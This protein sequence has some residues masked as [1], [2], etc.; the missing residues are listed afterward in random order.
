MQHW[1]SY[2]SEASAGSHDLRHVGQILQFTEV[3]LNPDSALNKC[4]HARPSLNSKLF[5]ELQCWTS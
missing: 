3:I 4:V 5:P 1:A 2:L